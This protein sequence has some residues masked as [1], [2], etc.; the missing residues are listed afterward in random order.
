MR[1]VSSYHKRR[2]TA[3]LRG[4]TSASQNAARYSYSGQTQCPARAP[5][6]ATQ[7]LLLRRQ[8]GL[9]SLDM[10]SDN[11]ALP[12][13]VVGPDHQ[14]VSDRLVSFFLLFMVHFRCDFDLTSQIPPYQRHLVLSKFPPLQQFSIVIELR[15]TTTFSLSTTW[16]NPPIA[17]NRGGIEAFPIPYGGCRKS[18]SIHDHQ[19]VSWP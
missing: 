16:R 17:L 1:L 2:S 18:S 12:H 6:H 13:L 5:V 14:L 19:R 7:A 9:A 8:S 3:K 4:P 15:P 10:S 11:G